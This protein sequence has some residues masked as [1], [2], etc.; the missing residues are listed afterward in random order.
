MKKKDIDIKKI[1]KDSK[2]LTPKVMSFFKRHTEGFLILIFFLMVAFWGY[3]FYSYA[4]KSVFEDP[5]VSVTTLKVKE[6]QLKQVVSDIKSREEE[7]AI[8]INQEYSPF[9][10]RTELLEPQVIEETEI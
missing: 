7:K 5:I 4:Y 9:S 8:Y 2:E 10:D 1:I 6:D 3:V